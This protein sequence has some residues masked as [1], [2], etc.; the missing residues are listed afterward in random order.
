MSLRF[1]PGVLVRNTVCWHLRFGDILEFC[2]DTKT[3]ALIQKPEGTYF[4]EQSSVRVVRTEDRELGLAV[5]SKLSIQ[6]WGR[7]ANS[8]GVVGWVLQI[9]VQLE[10]LL[11]LK[12]LRKVWLTRII[13]FDEDSIEILLFAAHR[14]F[15]VQLESMQF[16]EL[17]VISCTTEY[18][19][20]RSFYAA[21][22]SFSLYIYIIYIY[23]AAKPNYFY[24]V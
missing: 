15:M 1:S 7:K 14:M 2:L 16:K 17:A 11:R 23:K 12:P 4:T 19:P 13:G 8:N 5:V 18:Y 20:Y 3:L 21:G 9:T 10:K 6:L 22:N 24:Y